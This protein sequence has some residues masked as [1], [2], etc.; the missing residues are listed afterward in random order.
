MPIA[1][2]IILLLAVI[3]SIWI[4][5]AV[6]TLRKT[7]YSRLHLHKSLLK[8]NPITEEQFIKECDFKFGLEDDEKEF[9]LAVRNAI[10]LCAKVPSGSVFPSDVLERDIYLSHWLWGTNYGFFMKTLEEET[11]FN[12][13]TKFLD[14]VRDPEIVPTVTVGRFISEFLLIRNTQLNNPSVGDLQTR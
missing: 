4:I 7:F 1:F 11:G 3:F 6:K 12:F 14:S 13:D 8:R 10:S 5:F 2:E 9:V